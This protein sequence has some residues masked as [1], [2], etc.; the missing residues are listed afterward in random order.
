MSPPLSF[1]W[2]QFWLLGRAQGDILSMFLR[3]MQNWHVAAFRIFF[4]VGAHIQ[5]SDILA[6]SLYIL[7]GT[8]SSTDTQGGL[9]L[10]TAAYPFLH[11]NCWPTWQT[12][13][14][15]SAW[16]HAQLGMTADRGGAF[17]QVWIELQYL[18]NW[19]QTLVRGLTY[20][21]FFLLFFSLAFG[22]YVLG[23]LLLLALPW[24]AKRS[25]RLTYAFMGQYL[26]QEVQKYFADNF[27]T[28]LLTFVTYPRPLWSWIHIWPLLGIPLSETSYRR[29][30][31][32]FMELKSIYDPYQ[33][34]LSQFLMDRDRSGRYHMKSEHTHRLRF[35]CRSI[36]SNL[37]SIHCVVH[38][39][40]WH[41]NWHHR[42]CL[43]FH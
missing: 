21:T 40:L 18:F 17:K 20:L 27:L 22:Y 2:Q 13:I 39:E 25:S 38:P 3:S 42:N 7:K 12:S 43:Y 26:Q 8:N 6:D 1:P 41:W 16:Q 37:I 28:D 5:I 23:F 14:C 31:L 30:S 4:L 11:M 36:C 9:L 33:Q 34:M 29:G 35:A 15:P 19:F 24:C 10:P 32:H